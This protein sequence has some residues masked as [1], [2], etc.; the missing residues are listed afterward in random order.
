MVDNSWLMAFRVFAWGF[1]G[2]FFGLI[3]LMFCT[4]V[5]S[6]VIRGTEKKVKKSS[7]K[8]A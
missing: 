6:A 2:V 3:I 5:I 4:K 7:I 8:G 1:S